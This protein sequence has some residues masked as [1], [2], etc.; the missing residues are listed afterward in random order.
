M[1]NVFINNQH[2]VSFSNFILREHVYNISIVKFENVDQ[3]L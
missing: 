3:K 1:K 2:F